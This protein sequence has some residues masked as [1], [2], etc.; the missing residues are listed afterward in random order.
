MGELAS[1]ASSGAIRVTPRLPKMRTAA[2]FLGWI[3]V[4]YVFVRFSIGPW[5]SDAYWFWRMWDGGL[6]D[7]SWLEYGAYVYSPAFAQA[8]W[9]LTLLPWTLVS[10]M[11]TGAQLMA[12]VWMLGPALAAAALI[13]PWPSVDGYGNAVWATIYNGNPQ[14]LIAAAMVAGLR[15]P[16]AWSFVLLTKVT[17]GIGLLYFALRRE[18]RMLGVAMGIT[19]AVVFISS[20]VSPALWL[21]WIALLA[22][23]ATADTLP[24]EPILPLT[25]AVR[26]PMALGVITLASWRGWPWL[27]PVAS[28]LG[29]PAVQLGG[30]A[31]LAAVPALWL[32]SRQG[33]S[34]TPRP[35]TR[36]SSAGARGSLD[37]RA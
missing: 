15:W 12:L 13:V 21:E 19:G 23:A 29:L 31:L 26:L 3:V 36:M 7:R 24:K 11:W 20:V 14:I 6:Y 35:S 25:F 34:G 10:A 1:A 4:A 18:W 16:G 8:F 37:A 22:E 30:F 32:R 2:S 17:P 28:F 27:V 5:Q 33:S 9:P